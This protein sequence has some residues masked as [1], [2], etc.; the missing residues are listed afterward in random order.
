MVLLASV[1]F[2]PFEK[3]F[4]AKKAIVRVAMTSINSP[5][6]K[7]FSCDSISKS[8]FKFNLIVF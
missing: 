8:L 1:P 7:P 6:V 4:Q 3:A 2:S 5:T